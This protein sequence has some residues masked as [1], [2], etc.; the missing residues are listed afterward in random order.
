MSLIR[1]EINR[2]R[3]IMGLPVIKEQVEIPADTS[4]NMKNNVYKDFWN[5]LI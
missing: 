1:E 2:V 5:K 3:E 4:R